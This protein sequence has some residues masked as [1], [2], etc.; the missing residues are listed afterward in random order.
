MDSPAAEADETRASKRARLTTPSAA[1]DD[2][3]DL[4]SGLDDDVLLR[5]LALVPN[6]VRACAVSR[7]WRGLW[8]RVP[9]LRFASSGPPSSS[10]AAEPCAALERYVSFVNGILARRMRSDCCPVESLEISYTTDDDSEDSLGQLM[11][12]SVADAAQGWIRYAFQ[13]GLKSIVMDLD[14]PD[15]DYG[16]AE[17]NNDDHDKPE[18]RLDELPTSPLRLETIR[19][20]LGGARLRLFPNAVK[21]ASV[22]DLSLERIDIAGGDG[23]HLLGRLVSSASCPRL[24]KLRMYKIWFPDDSSTEELRLESDVLSELWVE[25][26]VVPL[27]LKTPSLRIFHI[28][29]CYN[30][31]NDG[32]LRVSAPRLEE[33]AFI[34]LGYPP[35]LLEVDG[36]LSRMRSL[37]IFLWSHARVSGYGQAH[38]NINML[39]IKQCSSL[40]CLDVTLKGRKVSEKDVDMIGSRVPHLPQITSLVVNVSNFFERHDF[41]AGVASLLTRFGN[42]RHLGLHLPIFDSMLSNRRGGLYVDCDHPDHWTSHDISMAHLQEVEVTGLTGTDCELRFMK[43]VLA[44]AKRLHKVDVSFYPECQHQDKMDAFERMLL[45]EGMWTSHRGEHKL[46]CLSN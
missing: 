9:A 28:D 16:E 30:G 4:I 25:E 14:L 38:N 32:V 1:G 27:E 26:V 13:H 3:A 31:S 45:G 7:R 35:G 18:V 37:K 20:A 46:T 43:T 39:L 15:D 34:Q 17:E 33:L 21:F 12:A 29:A 11:S 19:L 42:L 24:Q 8:A 44:S 22:T 36:H 10:S 2:D 23:A 6:A 40:T 41:G 5:I